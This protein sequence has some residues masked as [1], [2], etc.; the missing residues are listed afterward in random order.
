MTPEQENFIS[1]FRV[2][3]PK[4]IIFSSEISNT[5]KMLYIILYELTYQSKNC[6]TA[7]NEYLS[8]LLNI[9]KNNITK[10]INNLW[11]KG[12]IVVK[13]E[14]NNKRTISIA[15][16]ELAEE[17]RRDIDFKNFVEL[18]RTKYKHAKIPLSLFSQNNI[19]NF[20][21]MVNDKGYLVNPDERDYILSKERSNEVW[22]LLW[23]NQKKLITMLEQAKQK[24]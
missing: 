4:E 5:E 2:Q 19:H 23:G 12:F 6:C 18:M 10:A 20:R 7:S 24:S 15:E 8:N 22:K 21:V 11:R 3:I 17:N 16:K 13:M 1:Y 9:H 14:G